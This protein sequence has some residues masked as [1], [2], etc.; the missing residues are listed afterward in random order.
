MFFGNPP[1]TSIIPIRLP[2]PNGTN[3]IEVTAMSENL[4]IVVRLKKDKNLN[5]LVDEVLFWFGKGANE[6]FT[7]PESAFDLNNTPPQT[8]A[9]GFIWLRITAGP[10]F[11]KGLE[12]MISKNVQSETVNSFTIEY[13][14]Q[15]DMMLPGGEY[16][17]KIDN[18]KY[19]AEPT[20]L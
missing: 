7:Q 6:D 13:D 15:H 18:A 19:Y 5:D 2:N 9:E 16:L 8:D 20:V 11:I 12:F 3:S 10:E 1:S 17:T 4:T 14:G